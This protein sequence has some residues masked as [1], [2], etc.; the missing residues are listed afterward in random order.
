MARLKSVN[1]RPSQTLSLLALLSLSCSIVSAQK[2][3]ITAKDFDT[4][5]TITGQVLSHDGHLPRL[6]PLPA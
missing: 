5:R 6:R 4:W 1:L 3:P 2:R